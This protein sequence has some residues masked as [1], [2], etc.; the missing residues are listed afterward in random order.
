MHA[1]IHIYIYR[2]RG[3]SVVLS[4]CSSVCGCWPACLELQL[5]SN[6]L[7]AA[8]P[9]FSC[10]SLVYEHGNDSFVHRAVAPDYVIAVLWH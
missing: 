4:A 2:E 1:S 7:F 6:V 10:S 9:A 3:S 8:A 5:P